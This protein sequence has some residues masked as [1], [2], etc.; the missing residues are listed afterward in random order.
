M[1]P[2]GSISLP[3]GVRPS[4]LAGPRPSSAKEGR[5]GIGI[6]ADGEG[7]RKEED[8]MD[9][10]NG[11]DTN[12]EGEAVLVISMLS[13]CKPGGLRFRL[14]LCALVRGG[15]R[16]DGGVAAAIRAHSALTKSWCCCCIM[17]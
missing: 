6:G 7:D 14:S 9:I 11:G 16:R 15:L 13:G 2:R 8:V 4:E 17:V 12:D 10:E 1:R 5:G 3:P